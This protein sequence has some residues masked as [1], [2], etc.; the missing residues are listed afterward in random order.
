[1]RI[2]LIFKKKN[3]SKFIKKT[4]DRLISISSK[5]TNNFFFNEDLENSS[6]EEIN[7]C[8]IIWARQD[9][10]KKIIDQI[11]VPVIIQHER[12]FLSNYINPYS[13]HFDYDLRHL[14]GRSN[15]FFL[16]DKIYENKKKNIFSFT[17]LEKPRFESFQEKIE[18]DIDILFLSGSRHIQE[19]TMIQKFAKININNFDNIMDKI[20]YYY[21]IEKN[22]LK[23]IFG[24]IFYRSK[25]SFSYFYNESFQAIKFLRKQKIL[26][27]LL[28]LS[29]NYK[30]EYYGNNE[31][32]LW[33]VPCKNYLE[34]NQLNN[35]FARSKIVICPTPMHNSIIN[36]RFDLATQNFSIPLVEK[37][38]QYQK[39][40][41][42]SEFY[43]N[44][45]DGNLNFKIINILNNYNEIYSKFFNFTKN[46][47]YE[48]FSLKKFMSNI[49]ELSKKKNL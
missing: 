18:K 32:D 17:E 34:E 49:I 45:H 16:T 30:V 36:E 21:K 14:F 41:L 25:N 39:I 7:N 9:I 43:F 47:S 6:I 19:D 11:N 48:D 5:K 10:N 24:K 2:N 1:M 4:A 13:F 31:N 3:Y 40:N 23:K 46:I 20:H 8:D 26:K 15:I 38:P 22:L 37:Y 42:P 33:K 27:E 12:L 28:E 35:V 29:K 44:Y